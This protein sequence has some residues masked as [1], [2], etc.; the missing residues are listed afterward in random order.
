ML[1]FRTCLN[2]CE[3]QAVVV[4]AMEGRGAMVAVQSLSVFTLS[5]T[6]D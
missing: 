5:A 3:D 6:M 1:H 2:H 4:E